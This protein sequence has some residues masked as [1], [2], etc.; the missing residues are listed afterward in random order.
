M[1]TNLTDADGIVQDGLCVCAVIA[2]G[3]LGSA[4][5]SL[6]QQVGLGVGAVIRVWVD[7]QGQPLR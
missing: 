1:C 6:Q 3:Q 2:A 5:V 7:L 4:E